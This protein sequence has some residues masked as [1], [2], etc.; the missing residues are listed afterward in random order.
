MMILWIT[1]LSAASRCFYRQNVRLYVRLIVSWCPIVSLCPFVSLCPIVIWCPISH[2]CQ[3]FPSSV[4]AWGATWEGLKSLVP[5]RWSYILSSRY[6]CFYQG[7]WETELCFRRVEWALYSV[8]HGW[9]IFNMKS[10]CPLRNYQ[11]CVRKINIGR[12]WT[13]RQ[14]LGE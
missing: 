12:H 1:E 2:W 4:L 11:R 7:N 8:V 3:V 6:K 13:H 10:F 14:K 9:I 5:S